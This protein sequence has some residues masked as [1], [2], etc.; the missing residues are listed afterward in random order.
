MRV[1][2]LDLGSNSFHALIADVDRAG[3]LAV[4]E[5]AKRMPRIG[6]GIFRTG[7]ISSAARKSAFRAL[8]ELLPVVAR[9]R[10]DAIRA[11]ATAAVRD[12]RNGGAFVAEVRARFGLDVRIIS[13]DEEARL[14]YAGARARLGGE[15]GY[16]TLFDLGG[17]SLEAIV[18]DGEQ[19]VRTASAPLGVLRALVERPLSDPPTARELGALEPT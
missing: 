8:D 4:V 16:A 12:A 2:A 19:I 9:H 18:G 3:R 15:L 1:A 6:E 17:G 7:S 5:R 14:A 11:V 13:G 10:P